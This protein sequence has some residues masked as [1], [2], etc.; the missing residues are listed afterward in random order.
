MT[1]ENF[2][3]QLLGLKSEL[4]ELGDL[5]KVAID[6]SINALE[7]QNVDLALQVIDEDAKINALEE[8]IN[9]NAT[10]LIA[11]EQPLATDL[12][13]II[14][15]M[16]VT[17]DIERIG[18]LAVNIAKSVIR[19]GKREFVEPLNKIP[20]MA[21]ITQKMIDNIL[22]AFNE[23]DIYKARDVAKMDDEVDKM[24]GGLVEEL[25]G[26]MTKN[27]DYI[28]QIIQ[29]SFICRY[30]ERAADHSTN[31]SEAIIYLVKGKRYDL[32]S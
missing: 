23:E 29:L 8:E 1:R 25:M 30:L 31:I 14:A 15:I 22:L 7:N 20:H 18:D 2:E 27:P 17:T 9:E 19:I 26:L 5:A 4:M 28:A 13:K 3:E 24:Y 21:S 32:N 16:K 6:R 12:R 10:W 11:K